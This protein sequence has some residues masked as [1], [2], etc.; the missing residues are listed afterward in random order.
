MSDPAVVEKKLTILVI[1]VLVAIVSS[2]FTYLLS[3]ILE[4]GPVLSV[5]R[6]TPIKYIDQLGFPDLQIMVKGKPVKTVYLNQIKIRNSGSQPLRSIPVDIVFSSTSTEFN[7]VGI[8]HQTNP[9]YVFGQV[10]DEVNI[11][12]HQI[13][14][15]YELLNPGDEDIVS[16]LTNSDSQVNV[17]S[18]AA[19]MRVRQDDPESKGRSPLGLVWLSF[20]VSI[21][22][23]LLIA[24]RGYFDVR[25]RRR[26]GLLEPKR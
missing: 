18:K 13:G 9:P 16:V 21:S 4:K 25:R 7:V 6:E 24:A 10:K 2:G 15:N 23:A 20:M 11:D 5:E 3:K 1:P 14:L 12:G 17:Y 8:N 26:E 22:T 19:G